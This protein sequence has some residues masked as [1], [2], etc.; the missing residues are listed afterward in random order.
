MARNILTVTE[1]RGWSN[2]LHSLVPT[3]SPVKPNKPPP[4]EVACFPSLVFTMTELA[5][6]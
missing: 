4:W 1:E 6:W 5:S 3:H 2:M